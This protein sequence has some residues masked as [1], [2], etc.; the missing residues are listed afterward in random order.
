MRYSGEYNLLL[1]TLGLIY[2]DHH[3]EL[4]IRKDITRVVNMQRTLEKLRKDVEL[5]DEKAKLAP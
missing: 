4:R 2:F 3:L 5:K 1:F